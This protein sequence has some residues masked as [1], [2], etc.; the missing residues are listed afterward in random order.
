[1]MMIIVVLVQQARETLQTVF[2][3][4]FGVVGVII[5]LKFCDVLQSFLS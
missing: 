2:N 3:L 4:S 5:A 1:M